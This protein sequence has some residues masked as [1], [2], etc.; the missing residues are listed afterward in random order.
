[1][2]LL[3][4]VAGRTE[5][6]RSTG[7]AIL[8]I[9]MLVIVRTTITCMR[10]RAR[11]DTELLYCSKSLLLGDLKSGPV[12]KVMGEEKGNNKKERMRTRKASEQKDRT[13]YCSVVL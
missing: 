7:Q 2:K 11:G 12:Y 3:A 8:Y 10:I 5:G 4:I 6:Q 1:M 13:H 9:V